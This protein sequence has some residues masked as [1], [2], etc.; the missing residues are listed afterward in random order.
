MGQGK[1]QKSKSGKA[2]E[3]ASR[4]EPETERAGKADEPSTSQEPG[5]DPFSHA[6]S[7]DEDTATPKLSKPFTNRQCKCR[8]SW[9][10]VRGLTLTVLHFIQSEFHQLIL[11]NWY[12]EKTVQTQVKMTQQ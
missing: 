7:G 10:V 12:G 5:E 9:S 8:I 1:K 2:R 4:E 11:Q 6:N 3:T